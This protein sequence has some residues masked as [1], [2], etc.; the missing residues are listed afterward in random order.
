MTL[1]AKKED[2]FWGVD[3]DRSWL[4]SQVPIAVHR[5]RYLISDPI[6]DNTKLPVAR[7]HVEIEGRDQGYSDD[8]WFSHLPEGSFTSCS[9]Y[10]LIILRG[11]EVV[12]RREWARN[13]HRSKTPHKFQCSWSSNSEDNRDVADFGGR[14]PASED[15]QGDF[16]RRLTVGDRVAIVSRADGVGWMG[17]TKSALI[18]IHFDG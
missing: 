16:V 10:E 2:G 11:N 7:L 8:R 4:S 18:E 13:P 5:D 3:G 14:K 6:P 15:D 1:G 9:W 17:I 12:L